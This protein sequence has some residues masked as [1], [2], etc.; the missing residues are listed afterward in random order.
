VGKG[1]YR[2]AD[3]F[4]Y[5]SLLL[6]RRFIQ[7]APFIV[8]LGTVGALGKLAI[9]SELVALRIA[10]LSP[11][12]ICYA[13]IFIGLG[14]LGLIVILEQFIAPQLQQRAIAQRSIALDKSAELGKGLGIWAR[15]EHH[16]LRIGEMDP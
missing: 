16:I 9:N 3:A 6:P 2:T 11:M 13:P 8:L 4:L 5:V 10:G 15:D 1:T 12:K 7:I 14:L